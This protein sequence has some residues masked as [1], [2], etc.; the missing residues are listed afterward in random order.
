[1]SADALTPVGRYRRN[2][3]RYGTHEIVLGLIPD[4]S[5]VL[6]V[7]SSTGY[8]GASLAQRNCRIWGLDRD[9]AAV[10]S[11]PACYEAAA[12]CDLDDLQELPW[13]GRNFDVVLAADVL[14]HLREPAEVLRTLRGAMKPNGLCVVSLPNVAH[15]S[16]RFMLLQGHFRYSETGLLDESHLRFFTFESAQ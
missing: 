5:T 16:V 13:P 10:A 3:A 12:V 9:P 2:W 11:L 8:L 14:E 15:V 6:D 4:G 7:G 1:M